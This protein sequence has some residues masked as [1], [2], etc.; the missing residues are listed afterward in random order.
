MANGHL[1]V[2]TPFTVFCTPLFTKSVPGIENSTASIYMWGFPFFSVRL[3]LA[4]LSYNWRAISLLV[5]H[6]CFEWRC[7]DFITMGARRRDNVMCA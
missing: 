3:A 4:G 7:V 5:F 6:R 1:R 2:P